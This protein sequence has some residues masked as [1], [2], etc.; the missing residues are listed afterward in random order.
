MA[1]LPQN[2]GNDGYLFNVIS[3]YDGVNP[4]A[5]SS[6]IRIRNFVDNQERKD[7][8]L[9]NQIRIGASDV[10]N[11]FDVRKEPLPLTASYNSHR[12]PQLTINPSPANFFNNNDWN[13]TE[14]YN[15]EGGTKGF[16]Y[17]QEY[18][19]FA[20]LFNLVSS[21]DANVDYYNVTASGKTPAPSGHQL[22]Q[23][24]LFWSSYHY[25]LT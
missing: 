2:Y 3:S 4:M 14:T 15:L 11:Y 6:R 13:V 21:D 8:L 20:N 19:T 18:L 7:Q 24:L 9:V 1:V 16:T 23:L 22:F 5:T 12:G 17:L 10:S 25:K